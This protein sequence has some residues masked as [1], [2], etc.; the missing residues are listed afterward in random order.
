MK[1]SLK[2]LVLAAIML[3]FVFVL[4][5][6]GDITVPGD[7]TTTETPTEAPTAAPTESTEAPTES[8]E[9]PTEKPTDAGETTTVESDEAKALKA[10]MSALPTGGDQ[11]TVAANFESVLGF[12]I[13]IPTGSSYEAHVETTDKYVSY[14]VKISGTSVLADEFSKT[15]GLV[16]T[17]AGYSLD[18]DAYYMPYLGEQLGFAIEGEKDDATGES[19]IIITV[20]FGYL[21]EEDDDETAKAAEAFK[22]VILA[23]AQSSSKTVIEASLKVMLGFDVTLPSGASYAASASTENSYVVYNASIVGPSTTSSD[24]LAQYKT[25][26]ETDGFKEL[27]GRYVKSYL[28]LE[29]GLAIQDSSS[30]DGTEEMHI[31]VVFGDLSDEEGGEEEKEELTQEEFLNKLASLLEIE[32]AV[33]PSEMVNAADFT[34]ETNEINITLSFSF[35]LSEGKTLA[36]LQTS[37]TELLQGFT[38]MQNDEGYSWTLNNITISIIQDVEGGTYHAYIIVNTESTGGDEIKTI[39]Q[40]ELLAQLASLLDV[41]SVTL[42]TGMSD[43]KDFTMQVTSAQI[44][45]CFNFSISE[46]SSIEAIAETLTSS[47]EGFTLDSKDGF[48]YWSKDKLNISLQPGEE[49]VYSFNITQYLSDDGGEGE[50]DPVTDEQIKVAFAEYLGITAFP[51]SIEKITGVTYNQTETGVNVGFSFSLSAETTE[52]AF[53]AEI[54][55]AL[56]GFDV[57]M[58]ESGIHTWT[59]GNIVFQIM[60]TAETGFN[61]IL[62]VTLE[63]AGGDETLTEDEIKAQ[64]LSALG[65][66]EF[67][68]VFASVS[69]FA[70]V[71]GTEGTSYDFYAELAEGTTLESLKTT[72]A[73]AFTGFTDLSEGSVLTWDSTSLSVSV[74]Y[75][76]T[77]C[78]VTVVVKTPV[79]E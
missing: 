20:A 38:L 75:S 3:M 74:S 45:L 51:T 47:L 64:V 40:E 70:C 73:A 27:E 69:G 55:T 66:T 21:P 49:G 44:Q 76:E 62:N 65:L 32:S 18:G 72:L 2:K 46:G 4:A 48:Y 6:C 25:A 23:F 71:E 67:P 34:M 42:P 39:T 26:L 12:S 36:D 24:L 53:F 37:M 78:Q 11:E 22:A 56:V 7:L 28:G 33:L 57:E 41:E 29:L 52:E 59:S 61:V 58:A 8:T 1:K 13:T 17:V 77:K 50:V 16:L 19:S 31:I 43:L 63:A 5:S 15:I 79:K 14:G 54:N 68:A 30:E 9:A 35:G 10:K 60:G